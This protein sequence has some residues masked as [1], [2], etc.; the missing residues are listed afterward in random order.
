MNSD[1]HRKNTGSSEEPPQR[2]VA[3][4]ACGGELEN[5]HNFPSAF[6]RGEKVYFCMR[7]C[8]RVFQQDPDA[9]MAGEVEHPAVEDEA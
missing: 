5:P 2:S 1:D 3:K 8:L 4:T 9:F 6:Y 7:A